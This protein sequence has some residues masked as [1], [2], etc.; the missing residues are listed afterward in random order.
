MCFAFAFLII[1]DSS[2][3]LVL[4]CNVFQAIY[5]DIVFVFIF[6]T[7]I[8]ISVYFTKTRF[9]VFRLLYVYLTSL[10][11]WSCR[12][13]SHCVQVYEK[14]T[15]QENTHQNEIVVSV[16][17]VDS[18]LFFLFLF[19][20]CA[21]SILSWFSV[22]VYEMQDSCYL[23]IQSKP[24]PLK[25]NKWFVLVSWRVIFAKTIFIRPNRKQTEKIEQTDYML[26]YSM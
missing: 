14:D 2:V 15:I 11:F 17:G 26:C 22:N 16:N 24:I 23:S 12:L 19:V 6:I 10:F 20:R 21:W 7:E 4:F 3:S 13:F 18:Q 5:S 9:V 25:I 8:S 1:F